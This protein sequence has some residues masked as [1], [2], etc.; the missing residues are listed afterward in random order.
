MCTRR[1][2]LGDWADFWFL[3]ASSNLTNL[4]DSV[5][6]TVLSERLELNAEGRPHEKHVAQREFWVSSQNLPYDREGKG[7][8]DHGGGGNVI[9]NL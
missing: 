7:G 6:R 1:N 2:R 4:N 9:Y 8:G 5:G 3:E